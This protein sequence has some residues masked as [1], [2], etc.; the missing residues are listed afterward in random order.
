M[1]TVHSIKNF[2]QNHISLFT[3]P[4]FQVQRDNSKSRNTQLNCHSSC[5]LP[6]QTSY[7]WYKNGRKIWPSRSW[8]SDTFYYADSYSCAVEG[9]ED[10]PAPPVCEFTLRSSTTMMTLLTFLLTLV[11]P[12]TAV[13]FI[14]IKVSSN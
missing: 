8:Y 14:L 2:Y 5:R 11:T 7:I 12:S 1:L 10:V 4:G 3:N 13:K 9:H 6:H